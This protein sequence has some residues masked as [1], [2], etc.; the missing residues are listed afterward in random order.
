MQEATKSEPSLTEGAIV[1][2]MVRLA[3]PASTGMIFN[4]LYNLTDIWFAG[5]LSDNALAG[6]SIASSVFFLL[7]SIGIGIGIQTGASAM[8]AP[9][10]GRGETHEVKGWLDNVSGLAI[11]FSAVSCVIGFFAARPLVVLLGAEPHI[12]PLAMEY[13]WVTLAGSVGFT[14]SFGAAGALMALGDTKSNRNALMIGFFANFGLNPFF[15]FVLD[16]GVS[17]IALATVV[18][19]FATAFYLFRV[20]MKRLNISVMPTFDKER[21]QKLLKQIVPASFNMLTIILGGFIT[22][23]LI[24]QFGSEHVAGYTVGLRLEQVLL[25][26]ALGLNSAVMAIA[27]QNMGV[28]KKYDRVAETYRKGLLIGFFMAVVSIP[29]MYFLSPL[30][31]SLFTND[32]AIK[33]TGITY[34]RIDTLAFYAYVVLFQSVAILQ[35]MQKPMFPMYLGIARQLVVPASINYVLI[36][37]WGYP[38]VSMFYTIVTVVILS[39]IIAFFYTRREIN[40]LKS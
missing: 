7:L 27:G 34:L 35:A 32:S 14:L 8:I 30:A 37:V 4:T 17:G 13:L 23:A 29:V 2:H 10:A 33:N 19:K 28:K 21:W 20:L 31:M 26:P 25:L 36:V 24:G 3:I 38:M 22:V 16:L 15:T 6:L 5:Y 1:G 39:A 12:E 18:I 40:R 9:G 11:A